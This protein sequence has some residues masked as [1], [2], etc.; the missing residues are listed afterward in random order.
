MNFLLAAAVAQAT[1]SRPRFDHTADMAVVANFLADVRQGN[2]KGDGI[3]VRNWENPAIA[4]FD[5]FRTYANACQIRRL[6]A[7]PSA[8]ERMPIA[9][10]WDCGR[11]TKV[12]DKLVWEERSAGFWVKDGRVVRLTFGKGPMVIITP[13]KAKTKG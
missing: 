5:S 8:T 12:A 3:E 1:T 10:E 2:A 6:Y 11:Y 4:N 7:I 9:V 13:P